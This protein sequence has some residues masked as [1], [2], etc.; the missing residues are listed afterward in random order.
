MKKLGILKTSQVAY[1]LEVCPRTIQR[2]IKNMTKTCRHLSQNVAICRQ[3]SRNVAICLFT[4]NKSLT[5]LDYV[6]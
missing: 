2:F 1:F 4:I 5:I 3:M 6:V